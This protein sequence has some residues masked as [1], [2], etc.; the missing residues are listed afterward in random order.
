MSDDYEK[1]AYFVYPSSERAALAKGLAVT[2]S[3]S[4]EV[5]CLNTEQA[6]VT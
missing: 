6:T 5:E 2:P 4:L 3:G 1:K